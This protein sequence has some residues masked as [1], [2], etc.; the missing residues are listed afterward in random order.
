MN[1]VQC[2]QDEVDGAVVNAAAAD[3]R[4]FGTYR[5]G[6]ERL[7]FTFA[8]P[9]GCA[10]T[11]E[12]YFVE[13]GSY[14]R[15]FD[16]AVNG[17]V[18]A[19]KLNVGSWPERTVF[20]REFDAVASDDGRIV[21]SFPRVWCNQAVVSAIAVRTADASAAIPEE[22]P[23]YPASAGL[24]WAE[25]CSQVRETTTNDQLPE[26]EQIK[27]AP[28]TP[29]QTKRYKPE[30]NA[31]M[32]AAA[33]LYRVASDYAVTLLVK[34][35]DRR[36]KKVRWSLERPDGEGWKVEASGE[37]DVPQS[38]DRFEIKMG[39][40]VNAGY[41]VFYYRCDGIELSAREMK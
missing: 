22:R 41:Y 12:M 19:S 13:P 9:P 16:V 3:Q 27:L 25:L 35:G 4:L 7:S 29:L 23:G 10:C 8:A 1:P 33:Y 40:T 36:G 15:V 6:R 18:V 5:F 2:S 32:E 31:G 39:T 20:R 28:L 14:G 21:V 30:H 37:A 17:K 24:T 26:S 38:G 34:G 11:V